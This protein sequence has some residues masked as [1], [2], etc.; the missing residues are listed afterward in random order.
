MTILNKK[1]KKFLELSLTLS[2]IL[3]NVFIHKHELQTSNLYI[4][5]KYKVSEFNFYKFVA[6][7]VFI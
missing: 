1:K 4:N 3:L 7:I 6:K 5:F 2:S